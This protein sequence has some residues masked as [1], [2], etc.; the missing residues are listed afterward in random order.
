MDLGRES[1]CVKLVRLLRESGAEA[2]VHLA[3]TADARRNGVT[4]LE[5]MWQ[6]NVAGTA[7]VMEAIAE[8]NRH[9]GKSA[10][11]S[12]RA[13]LRCTVRRLRRW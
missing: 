7:R 6:I 11:S 1:S 8:V 13:A 2:V 3:A 9:G 4:D 5:R 12:T 10:S